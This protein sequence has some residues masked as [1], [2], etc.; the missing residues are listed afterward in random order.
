M[1]KFSLVP[2]NYSVLL[3][4]FN[5]YYFM[6]ILFISYSGKGQICF[7]TSF[8]PSRPD[9][10]PSWLKNICMCQ[11]SMPTLMTASLFVSSVHPVMVMFWL[12]WRPSEEFE[13]GLPA[14]SFVGWG[15]AVAAAWSHA[16]S[17]VLWI[18][19]TSAPDA[20]LLLARTE[21]D[22]FK[23]NEKQFVKK[24]MFWNLTP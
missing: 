12:L 10:P 1:N 23:K 13:L 17:K 20:R 3:D 14:W 8:S 2:T 22:P 16:A 18:S 6:I 7:I 9:V 4:E 24:L 21:Q 11:F 5:H 15:A 19:N